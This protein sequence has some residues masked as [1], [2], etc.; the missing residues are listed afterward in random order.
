MSDQCAITD[1][2]AALILKVT[3]GIDKNIFTNRN[4]FATIRVER[5]K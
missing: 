3:P 2:N 1:R 4:V 5:R